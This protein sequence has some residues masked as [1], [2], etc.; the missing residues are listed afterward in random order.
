LSARAPLAE[1]VGV[2]QQT[3]APP[4]QILAFRGEQRTPRD[5]VEE[6]HAQVGLQGV[7][8]T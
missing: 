7:N 2:G 6:R 8:L 4:Q 1:R 3:P 5:T